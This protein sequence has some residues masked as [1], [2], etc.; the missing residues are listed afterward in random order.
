[1]HVLNYPA[2]RY[3]VNVPVPVRSAHAEHH[4]LNLKD[5]AVQRHT[6]AQY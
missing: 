4:L 5:E 1:M 3:L 6:L 2:L